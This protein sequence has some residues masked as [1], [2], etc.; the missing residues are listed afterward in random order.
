[1]LRRAG[2][3][4][5][6]H[7]VVP[8]AADP[9]TLVT[10]RALL[11]M[12]KEACVVTPAMLKLADAQCKYHET[13][14]KTPRPNAKEYDEKVVQPQKRADQLAAAIV[15]YVYHHCP[16]VTEPDYRSYADVYAAHFE[17]HISGLNLPERDGSAV[18]LNDRGGAKMTT[19]T[20]A[21]YLF[22]WLAVEGYM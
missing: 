1:L 10:L 8:A 2:K 19:N 13:R 5:S 4:A 17:E 6:K 20:R 9:I 7:A 11:K 12:H 21:S 14:G 22:M 18:P 15:H 16:W 3:V